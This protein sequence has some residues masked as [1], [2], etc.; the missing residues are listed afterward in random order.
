[1]ASTVIINQFDG[2]QA[3]D[4]RTTSNGQSSNSV[5]FDTYSLP[6]TIIPH[7]DLEA[8]TYSGG[9]IT[10]FDI[11]DVVPVKISGNL[12]L[13]GFGRESAASTKASFF[14]KSS[15]SDITA[16]WSKVA[17]TSGSATPMK[18]TLVEYKGAA[19]A[20]DSVHN[21]AK[22][23]TPS[24]YTS[25]GTIIVSSTDMVPKPFMHPDDKVLYFG[26]G[27]VLASYDGSTFDGSILILPESVRITSLTNYGGY[28]AI[29]TESVTGESISQ[30]FIW[31]RDTSLT[32]VTDIINFGTEKL[33]VLENIDNVLIG[34]SATENIGGFTTTEQYKL[35]VRAYAGGT[36]QV[37]KEYITSSTKRLRA[38]KAK[39][40]SRLYFGFDTDDAIWVVGKNPQGRWFCSRDRFIRNGSVITGTLDGLS[41]VGDVAF[42]AFTDGGVGSYLYR[43]D[44]ASFADTSVYE[45]TINPG[46]TVGD[47]EKKKKLKAVRVSWQAPVTN[48]AIALSYSTDTYGTSYTTILSSSQSSSGVYSIDAVKE[49]TGTPFKDFREIMFRITSTGAARIHEVRYTYEVIEENI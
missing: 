28:L 5:N 19:Y 32:T 33:K 23:T 38:F 43:T 42:I 4:I 36:P 12:E 21:L 2:G 31:D 13:I 14:Q 26:A 44:L 35:V 1:M 15:N 46:M 6:N 27:N 45:T 9:T 8:E 29:A 25:V 22:Y 37:I 48:G 34:V 24:T 39:Q 3:Q 11:T 10:D 41:F 16:A 47:R 20:I 18:G 30:V 40:N 49:N 17:T 7:P